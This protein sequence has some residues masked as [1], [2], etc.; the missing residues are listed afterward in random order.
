MSFAPNKPFDLRPLPPPISLQ[1]HPVTHATFMEN[2]LGIHWQTCGKYL[3]ALATL[4]ILTEQQSGKY[5]FFR[6]QHAF[7][8]LIV[9]KEE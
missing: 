6:N 8:A 7:N 2:D 3:R 9:K 5:K 4:G 1:A